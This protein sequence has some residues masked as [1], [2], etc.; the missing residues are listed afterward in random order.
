MLATFGRRLS[1]QRTSPVAS[2]SGAWFR[3]SVVRTSGPCHHT[4][5]DVA[6]DPNVRLRGDG[7]MA[8]HSLGLG[9]AHVISSV[10]S[11]AQ[12]CLCTHSVPL[13]LPL[14]LAARTLMVAMRPGMVV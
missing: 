1:V 14:L 12:V 3:S 7:L 5:C 2:L 8:Q 13:P 11:S 9:P 10:I 4:R 6:C